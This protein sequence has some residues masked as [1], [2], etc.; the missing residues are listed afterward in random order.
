ME[1]TLENK[2]KFFA[3]Y[4]AQKVMVNGATTFE[5]GYLDDSDPDDYLELKPISSISEQ[6]LKD[7]LPLVEETSYMRG[8]MNPNMVKQIFT[9]Y[10]KTSK[11][12]GQQWSNVIDFL[13]G[14]GY[15]WEWNGVSVDEQIKRGWTVLKTE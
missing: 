13:R 11:L 6:H 5:V 8:Y 4:W 14:N 12:T 2:A 7:L 15:A 10:Q 1:N 9:Y 3:Q